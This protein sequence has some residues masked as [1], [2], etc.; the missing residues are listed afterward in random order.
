MTPQFLENKELEREFEK[1]LKVK[2]QGK[3]EKKVLELV[4]Q[5][6]Q[7][8]TEDTERL[9]LL[10]S[11]SSCLFATG[12]SD[13]YVTKMEALFD[14]IEE[15]APQDPELF[16][17]FAEILMM[18]YVEKMRISFLY[19]AKKYAEKACD[20]FLQEKKQ[21]SQV[22]EHFFTLGAIQQA[23]FME[24]LDEEDFLQSE[25]A[26]SCAEKMGLEEDELFA[27]KGKLLFFAAQILSQPVL[28]KESIEN[29]EKVIDQGEFEDVALMVKALSLYAFYEEDEKVMHSAK[30]LLEESSQLA[31]MDEELEEAEIF[32]LIYEGRLFG[33]SKSFVE[34]LQKL[35]ET[36]GKNNHLTYLRALALFLLSDAR[37]DEE[38]LLE[39]LSVF[40]ECAHTEY[41]RY[42]FFWNY[43][44]L[45]F[46]LL[47]EIRENE[48][49][50]EEAVRSF[51]KALD[52]SPH[53]VPD[54]AY[55]YAFALDCLGH[56]ADDEHYFEE[57]IGISKE[58][59]DQ[60]MDFL[61]AK[62]Q[63]AYSI[64]HLAGTVSDLELF[65]SA[66]PC[67]QQIVEEDPD[68]PMM[69][70]EFGLL[71]MHVSELLADEV[72]PDG[73]AFYD[74]AEV[75]F[76][77]ALHLGAYHAHF[78]LCCLYAFTDEKEK[79]LEQFVQAFE[80]NTLPPYEDIKETL[81]EE[82]LEDCPQY[83][84]IID[85]LKKRELW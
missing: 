13:E 71:W 53:L 48:L 41:G 16:S 25:S 33:K 2:S 32:H 75:C 12:A 23:L 37:K 72:L 26:F 21:G 66:V 22:A 31:G 51:E 14:Q 8:K 77:R 4:E 24:T 11:Y 67:F 40:E 50:L 34:A 76:F 52:L 29:L 15:Q 81:V 60:Y 9:L 38:L 79:A 58:L 70:V 73:E 20:I 59:L 27:E 1:V 36:E 64:A 43:R 45:A 80:K 55:N 3:Q 17:N 69:W 74:R 61:P 84:Q 6:L 85:S 54:W 39:S 10:I 63:L 83:M 7:S 42:G 78:N 30:A 28:L 44:G 35:H 46:F 57:A 62:K 5:N 19:R 47:S 68:D 18:C 82:L 56:I 65:E 49:Y